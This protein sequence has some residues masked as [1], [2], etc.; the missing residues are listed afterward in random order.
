MLLPLKTHQTTWTPNASDFKVTLNIALDGCI[1]PTQSGTARVDYSRLVVLDNFIDEPTRCQLYEFLTAPSWAGSTP[2]G[3]KWDRVTADADGKPLTW[4]LHGD[5][6]QGLA[7][8]D[9]P[10]K[11][12]VQSRLSLLYPDAVISH[13]PS[14][15]IQSAAEKAPAAAAS[16]QAQQKQQQLMPLHISPEL[17]E[18][19]LHDTHNTENAVAIG[20]QHQQQ[21]TEHEADPPAPPLVPAQAAAAAASHGDS[22]YSGVQSRP[23]QQRQGGDCSYFLANA[24]VTG[25][26]FSW[27][28]DADPASF[29]SA[30]PWSMQHGNYCNR[31]PGKP[32]FVSLLLYLDDSWPM[33][34]N[35]E[36]LFLDSMTETGLVVRPRPYRAVLFDQDITH[37]LSAPSPAAGRP[38]YSLVMKLVMLPKKAGAACSIARPEWGQPTYFGSAGQV[39]RAARQ[40]AAADAA[41]CRKRPA[42]SQAGAAA[43]LAEAACSSS[44][45]T[46]MAASCATSLV[47]DADREGSQQQQLAHLAVAHSCCSPLLPPACLPCMDF[48]M[49]Q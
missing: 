21:P 9:L 49:S 4:G 20:H 23:T 11:V 31:E 45:A 18:Q 17:E 25:D 13:M 8:A 34:N 33:D 24:A 26:A 41:G 16:T 3:S 37:R 7:D 28:I 43:E 22:S 44:Y 2:P 12:E 35:A 36:T 14:H 48:A 6:L 42:A 30:T 5:V 47:T 27:H 19:Q 46:G 10:A 29:P 32:L 38:R 40:A 39:H 15:L 1:V